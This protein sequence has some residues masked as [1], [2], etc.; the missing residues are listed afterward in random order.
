M[1]KL[2]R[3]FTDELFAQ[4]YEIFSTVSNILV[5]LAGFA[6]VIALMGLFGMAMHLTS[7]RRR[8]M[9]AAVRPARVL[10]LE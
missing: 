4:A 5:G 10:H 8:K 6:F 1:L 7:R 2:G 3:Q 9:A